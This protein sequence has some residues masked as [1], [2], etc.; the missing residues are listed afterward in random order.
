MYDGRQQRKDGTR[1]VFVAVW[2]KE[3]WLVQAGSSSRPVP[4]LA[5]GRITLDMS[6]LPKAGMWCK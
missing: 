3:G 4:I 2:L 5:Y 6:K 1:P